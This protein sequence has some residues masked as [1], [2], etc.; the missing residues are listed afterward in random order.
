MMFILSTS[1][2]L[3]FVLQIKVM[4]AKAGQVDV[5]VGT[6]GVFL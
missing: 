6:D 5:E 1:E 3:K 2:G 4:A